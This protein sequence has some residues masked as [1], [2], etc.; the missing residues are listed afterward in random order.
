MYARALWRLVDL[1]EKAK[2]YAAAVAASGS[3]S[4]I[5]V[6][7]SMRAGSGERSTGVPTGRAPAAVCWDA[8]RATKPNKLTNP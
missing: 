5:D 2:R 6:R 3:S 4:S 1:L 8:V 7:S